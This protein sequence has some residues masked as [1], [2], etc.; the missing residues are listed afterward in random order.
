[1]LK[2][3]YI[4]ISCTADANMPEPFIW[5]GLG[6]DHFSPITR[7]DAENQ[8]RRCQRETKCLHCNAQIHIQHLIRS[9]SAKILYDEEYSRTLPRHKVD[10]M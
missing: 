5:F 9:R 7:E 10:K 1:M 3:K 8:I 2:I 4:V 6:T